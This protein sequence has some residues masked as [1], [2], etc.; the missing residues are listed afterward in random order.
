MRTG[1]PMGPE[2]LAKP[3]DSQYV[4]LKGHASSLC[5]GCRDYPKPRSDPCQGRRH[6]CRRAAAAR[7][8]V[9][10]SR[11]AAA[12][13]EM[14]QPPGRHVFTRLDSRCPCGLSK[15]LESSI[16]STMQPAIRPGRPGG[17]IVLLVHIRGTLA[18][19]RGCAI[20]VDRRRLGRPSEAPAQ[21]CATPR[22]TRTYVLY[23]DGHDFRAFTGI[24]SSD[25]YARGARPREAAP[26]RAAAAARGD[27]H[28]ALLRR[29][30]QRDGRRSAAGR[31]RSGRSPRLVGSLERGARRPLG[32]R[33]RG[34]RAARPGR[35]IRRLTSSASAR[36]LERALRW[37]MIGSAP[38]TF[39]VPSSSASDGAAA[40]DRRSARP[41]SLPAQRRKLDSRYGDLGAARS[42]SEQAGE[43]RGVHRAY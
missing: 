6:P 28:P 1:R 39:A 42:R 16:R 41:P 2:G 35:L 22:S 27:G 7:R 18:R 23:A 30:A 29:R 31:A 12:S 26:G 40:V 10:G 21:V 38:P 4:R 24:R 5:S 36:S 20:W 32:G 25:P 14:H 34:V 13:V 17:A 8:R 9:T 43:G 3:L 15:V 19:G 37:A 33:H 11:V